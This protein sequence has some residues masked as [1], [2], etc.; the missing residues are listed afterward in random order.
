MKICTLCKKNKS[1]ECF[2]KNKS[3]KDGLNNI[4]RECSSAR[5][6]QYYNE[7]KDH[8]IKVIRDRNLKIINEN[9]QKL[10][11]YYKNNPCVD[12][13]EKDP[14]VLECDHRDGVKKN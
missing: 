13:Q 7:N 11:D 6:K 4:C 5:S 12:C 3:R 14:I 10:F 1:L 2:N 9:R 8:H